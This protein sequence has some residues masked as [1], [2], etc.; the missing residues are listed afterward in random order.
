APPATLW[1]RVEDA[2]PLIDAVIL[3][4]S[5]FLFSN[6]FAVIDFHWRVPRALGF[7]LYGEGA[8][9]DF[10]LRRFAG[11]LLDDG[12]YVAGLAFTCLTECGRLGL[13]AAYHQTGIRY[14]THLQFPEGITQ[15]GALL[16]DQL[17]PRGIGSYLTVDGATDRLGAWSVTGAYEVRSG[18]MYGSALEGP[19]SD[20]VFI[21]N[22]ARPGE[23]RARLMATWTPGAVDA[24]TTVSATGGIEHVTDFDF[25]DGARRT[26]GLFQVVVKVR[27]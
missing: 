20:F 25:V 5:D 13:R 14:Y 24:R 6:K 22:A 17:G 11:S 4:H 26:N 23:H 9:D 2:I 8:L 18:N 27:P 19:D 21:R 10:E 15:Q 16:G 12:G 3:S 7:E 1:E